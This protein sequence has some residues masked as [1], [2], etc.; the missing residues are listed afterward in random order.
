MGCGRFRLGRKSLKDFHSELTQVAG[1]R[2]GWNTHITFHPSDAP[3]ILRAPYVETPLEAS[4]VKFSTG[5]AVDDDFRQVRFP[6][7]PFGPQS[8]PLHGC[9]AV[10]AIRVRRKPISGTSGEQQVAVSSDF[11]NSVIS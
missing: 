8:V 1:P 9:H 3:G 4:R 2:A 6:L 10:I 5:L 7:G 11:V